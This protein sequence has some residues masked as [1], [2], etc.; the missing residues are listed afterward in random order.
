VLP[1]LPVTDWPEHTSTAAVRAEHN[2][3]LLRGEQGLL[4]PFW[5]LDV[6]EASMVGLDNPCLELHK[7]ACTVEAPRRNPWIATK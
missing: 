2:V 5:M 7:S 1:V 3:R 4:S 6:P